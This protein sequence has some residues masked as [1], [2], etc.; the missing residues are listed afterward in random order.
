[1]VFRSGRSITLAAAIAVVA[2][3]AALTLAV[4]L[5]RG[6]GATATFPLSKWFRRA[7]RAVVDRPL[8]QL[9]VIDTPEQFVDTFLICNEGNA[10]LELAQGPS[11]CKCTVTELPP[12]RSRRAA[13]ARSIWASATRRRAI[14]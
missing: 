13:R 8:R 4:I 3:G 11:T 14:P 2:A 12:G 7:P 6:A 1:M 5:T 10:P 9:G